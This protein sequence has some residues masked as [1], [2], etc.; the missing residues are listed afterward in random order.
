MCF[1]LMMHFVVDKIIHKHIESIYLACHK[2]LYQ[3]NRNFFTL[4][5]NKYKI[6]H[7]FLI[8]KA[9]EHFF[10]SI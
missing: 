6:L 10:L 3:R 9:R 1:N 2:L 7:L 8:N 5:V 4:F